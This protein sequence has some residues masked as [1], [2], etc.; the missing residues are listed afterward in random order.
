M[1]VDRLQLV[2]AQPLLGVEQVR[3]R[4]AACR[5]RA[6][7]RRWRPRA[8][9]RSARRPRAPGA[10]RAAPSGCCGRTAPAGSRA[11]ASGAARPAWAAA[12]RRARRAATLPS[13]PSGAAAGEERPARDRRARRRRAATPPRRPGPGRC[14]RRAAATRRCETSRSYR[15][16]SIVTPPSSSL[17]PWRVVDRLRGL[18][19]ALGA[20]LGDRLDE[21]RRR[22]AAG[23]SRRHDC[24]RSSSEANTGSRGRRSACAGATRNLRQEARPRRADPSGTCPCAFYNAAMN[25]VLAPRVRRPIRELPSEL[26]S[27]IAAGEVVERPASVVREL[28]DNAHRRR[29]DQHRRAPRRAAASA[30]SSSRTTATASPADE[31]ARGAAPPRDQQDRARSTE[32]EGVATMGFRGEA[33]AAIASVAERRADQPHAPAPAR[34][35]ARRAHR[36]A[37]AGRARRRH[38]GRGARAVLQHAGAAQVPEDR[39]HRA[40]PL[41]RGSAPPRAGA[42][43]ARVRGL[44][45][46][47]AGR[48]LGARERGRA[49]R[50][51]LLG[52]AFVDAQPRGRG[53]P[54]RPGDRAAAPERPS[55]RARAPTCST[56]T[57]TAATCATS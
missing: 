48:A 14:T 4:C 27:Q 25:A 57:S 26:V 20:E 21:R 2:A 41:R 18:D 53:R 36:R 12:S 29:R 54:R 13:A 42:A 37:R 10:R 22:L 7:A 44:A 33:L 52:A 40:R 17:M 38:D 45:R 35:A 23:R 39:S 31:L 47:Q 56:S 55:R 6:A 24:S 19:R 46:R 50:R 28:L 32:L 1:D 11:R 34:D 15:L 49:R 9:R 8:P 16:W 43:R 3:R 5:G 30:P 51:R